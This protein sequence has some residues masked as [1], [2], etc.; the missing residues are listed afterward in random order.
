MEDI[1]KFIG[2]FIPAIFAVVLFRPSVKFFT[3]FLNLVA[4][5]IHEST[6]NLVKE[7]CF[8]EKDIKE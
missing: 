5:F 1:L 3:Y 2:P 6:N 8:N 4:E 7:N